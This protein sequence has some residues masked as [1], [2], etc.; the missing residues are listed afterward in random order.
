[1]VVIWFVIILCLISC[2]ASPRPTSMLAYPTAIAPTDPVPASTRLVLSLRLPID[3]YVPSVDELYEIEGAVDILT[4]HCMADRG[5]R[6]P[7]VARPKFGDSRNRRRYGVIEPLVARQYGYHAVSALLGPVTVYNAKVNRYKRL[8]TKALHAAIDPRNG[9]EIQAYDLFYHDASKPNLSLANKLEAQSLQQSA[10]QSD[11]RRVFHLWAT[12]MLAA[13][14]KYADPSSASADPRWA[15]TSKAGRLEIA[16]AEQD[17]SCKGQ[18][19]LVR[20]WFHVD[21]ELQRS[22]IRTNWMYFTGLGHWKHRAL[23]VAQ[24][25]K[26]GYR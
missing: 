19:D 1:M 3:A 25:I 16:T 22:M 24:R 6:W 15:G 5:Y 23:S 10:H 17:V 9:C 7:L 21:S 20:T 11:V 13:G 4:R 18:V 8:T 12:C 26:T 14:Y 2:S